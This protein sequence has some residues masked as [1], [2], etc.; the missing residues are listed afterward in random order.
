MSKDQLR[1]LGCAV[2]GALSVYHES[3][4]NGLTYGYPLEKVHDEIE[5]LRSYLDPLLR[6]LSS[7]S[8]ET[9]DLLGFPEERSDGPG[10]ICTPMGYVE[11]PPAL[12]E[13]W[14]DAP[15]LPL[16]RRLSHAGDFGAAAER[17]DELTSRV[18][19]ACREL[20][21]A[22]LPR[23]RRPD[24]PARRLAYSCALIWS[25][26][27]RAPLGRPFKDAWRFGKFVAAVFRAAGLP[28]TGQKYARELV[29]DFADVKLTPNQP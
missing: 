29:H 15:E 8:L 22:S 21:A 18:E 11:A 19:W 5:R 1:S 13:K 2:G 4:A 16:P 28:R 9:R 3:L 14:T 25:A 17:V 23:G 7:L 26:H 24:L 10:A 27:V 6:T 20:K 12:V